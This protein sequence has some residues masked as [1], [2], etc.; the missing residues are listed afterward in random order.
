MSVRGTRNLVL[1]GNI[2]DGE[3]YLEDGEIVVDQEKGIIA[4]VGRTG[5]IDVPRDAK[6]LAAP[7]QT[8]I[9]G[10]I[11][12]HVHFFGSK[13][14]DLM[15]WVST[16]E[17]LVALR[18][19]ADLQNLL[20]SG[21]TC[22]REMGS[23]GGSYLARAIREGVIDGPELLSC[24][25]SLGQTG[26]D[27][28]PT[29][30]PLHIA[31]ELS[32][33]YFCDGPWECRK[34]VRK[35]VRDGADFVKV[36]AATGSTPEPWFFHL[37]PQLSVE[38]LR[39]IVDEAHSVGLKVAGHAIGEDSMRNVVEAGVDSIEHGVALTPE[40][41]QEIKKKE[42]YYTPTL[43]IFLTNPYLR[44]FI[45]DPEKTDTL[46]VRRHATS[47]MQLAKEMGL[48]VV[49]GTDFGGTKEQPHGQ[50]YK[51]IA[52][53]AEYLGNREA[54][55]AATARAADCCGLQNIGRIKKGFNADIVV[56]KGN[57]LNEIEALAPA[58]I[59]H[60]FKQGKAIPLPLPR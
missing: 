31:Q 10:L 32:Y 54:L 50:N 1:K 60:V 51:E 40:I 23:K 49:C 19:V 8:V 20:K 5:E 15:A 38:E 48:K 11:D 59:T 33:S 16:P 17:T 36:Y 30:L 42:I 2:F 21:F 37:R 56:V 43:A 45:D 13:A 29:N 28:D 24:A 41:A 55:I 57:P 46:Y 22:V 26:G 35:V 18:S 3:A 27:D 52:A 53:L 4:D 58:N 6:V 25:R 47:D 12:T 7:G 44:S 14:Y 39:A 9:P 34:A